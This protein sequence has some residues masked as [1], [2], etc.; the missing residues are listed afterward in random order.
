METNGIDLRKCRG[1]G[2]KAKIEGTPCEGKIQVEDGD[3]YLC[4]NMKNGAGCRDRLGYKFSWYIGNCSEIDLMRTWVVNLEILPRDPKTYK[5]WQVGDKVLNYNIRIAKDAAKEVIFRSGELVI[6]KN[7]KNAIGGAYT[8]D[9]LYQL[10]FRLVLTD[11]EKQIL[12]GK[13]SEWK[14]YEFRQG[15]PVLV[16]DVDNGI[17]HITTFVERKSG[18]GRPF[19]ANDGMGQTGYYFCLP[20]NEKT[21]HLLGTTEDY[22]EE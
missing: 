1:F 20:Y 5:D 12:E 10:G 13:K 8:C 19:Y 16:R 15:E 2:F 21:M 9:E 14:P 6:C 4:Q 7:T 3:V 22:K 18:S 11:I 17:W